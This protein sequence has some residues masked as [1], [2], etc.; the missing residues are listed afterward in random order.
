MVRSSINFNFSYYLIGLIE[1][2]GT[3]IVPKS[4]RSLKGVL[5]YPSIQIS[6]HLRD[7]PLAQIIQKTLGF[8]FITRTKG[9]NA[10]RLTVNNYEGL[11]FLIHLFHGKFKTV[12]YLDFNLLI[13]FLNKRYPNLNIPFQSNP[14]MSSFDSN[15]WLSGFIDGD[16]HFFVNL[17]P[18]RAHPKG[19][20][21]RAGQ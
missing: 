1:S 8:G 18:P 21:W 17:N 11:I 10:Y 3:I 5:N 6:F 15:P 16:V 20:G 19:P 13:T 4:E 7:F 12:K 9:V 14:D 2:D